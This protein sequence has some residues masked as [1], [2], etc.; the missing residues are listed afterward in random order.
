MSDL[1]IVLKVAIEP[2]E[3]RL[4]AEDALPRG[5]A[6]AEI[7]RPVREPDELDVAAEQPQAGEELLGLLDR[8]AVILVRVQ[9]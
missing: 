1:T 4:E 2:A 5:T 8:T 6:T 3:D 9:Q 7:V